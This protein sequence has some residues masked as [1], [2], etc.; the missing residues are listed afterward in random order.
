MHNMACSPLV[1]GFSDKDR[2]LARNEAQRR[3]EI[4]EKLGLA[5][6]NGGPNMGSES[7]FAHLLG[8]GGELAVAD[9]LGLREFLYTEQRAKRGSSDLPP[10]IDVKTRS[11]H[12]Y[13][14]ICQLDERPGKVLVLVTMQNKVTLVHGWIKSEDAMRPE[15]KKDPAGGRPAYFV[16]QSA[17]LPLLTLRH[18]EMF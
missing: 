16:P 13:D 7:F 1:F 11:K 5:G 6:R 3:Q 12:Y 4:N 15:W 17:L 2:I 10:N 9:Y 18:A 8:A 14:L